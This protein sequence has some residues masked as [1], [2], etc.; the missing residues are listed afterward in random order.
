[1]ATSTVSLLLFFLFMLRSLSAPLADEPGIHQLQLVQRQARPTPDRPDGAD[2]NSFHNVQ[3]ED[4]DGI[5]M[6]DGSPGV[7]AAP[8]FLFART[9]P[10][11][12]SPS[13]SRSIASFK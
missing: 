13:F 6:V 3:F 2:K 12:V 9:G 11:N 5:G 10:E 8:I 4:F 7:E 1:M